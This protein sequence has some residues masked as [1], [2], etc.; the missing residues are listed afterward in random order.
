M[1]VVVVG[2]GLAGLNAACQLREAGLDV[3]VCEAA[4]VVGGRVRTDVVDGFRLD[5][6][7]QVLL[8]SYPAVR[9]LPGLRTL[10]LQPFTRG[11]AA[12][13]TGGRLV[14]TPPW[15]RPSG[16]A[17]VLRFALG[18]PR[19]AVA[20]GMFSAR[21]VA[22]P[23]DVLRALP[24]RTT[25]AGLSDAGVSDR[26]VE[27]VFR[28]FLAGVFLDRDLATSSR[29]FHLVWRSF[30]RG[31]AALPAS[32]MGALPHLL[33]ARLDPG[34]V[35]LG[36]SVSSVTD[37]G[38]RL[39]SGEVVRARAVVVATDG[40][41]AARLLPGVPAPSWH[42][43]TT[44]YYRLPAPA[45]ETGG[46]LL[47]DGTSGLL[48]NTAVVSNVAPG[49]APPGQALVAASVPERLDEDG[50]ETAVREGLARLYDTSTRD[51]DLL[52]SYAIPEALP[53]MGPDH[54]LR[55]PVRV[56]A[57]RYVCGDHRDTSSI[58]GAL[59]SGRRAAAAVLEDL[60]RSTT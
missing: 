11:V 55:R 38:V 25:S 53:A 50:L 7:F 54:P 4:D 20:V 8:P 33:A 30:L 41:T 23:A 58:Q 40:T 49:Y 60:A 26:T 42:G 34:T 17:D 24:R 19:D 5:R 46:T 56:A 3:T 32:G 47:V 9:A 18:R 39:G 43:V 21:D 28:P 6:G 12:E 57:G 36:T 13:G 27:D 29:V 52:A 10:R 37:D 48:V 44:Y 14:L 2:A 31:G 22:A 59:V 16:S 45:P 1:D 15:Q 51:W 35:R